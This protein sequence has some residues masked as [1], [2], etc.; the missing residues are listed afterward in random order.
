M[1]EK[2]LSVL[3]DTAVRKEEEAI[4][5][6]TDL[7]AQVEDVSV[8]DTL[9]FIASEERKHR[10]FLL[11]YREGRYGPADLKVSEPV[12]YRIA[13]YQEEPKAGKAMTPAEAFLLASHR[14]LRAHRFY[15]EL[16]ELHTEGELR[17]MILK[18]AGEELRHKEKMEYLYVN[19]AFP[20]TSGG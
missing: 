15:S 13:E 20:Q 2:N 17:Q 5:F 16:S 7:M 1:A 9:S 6:Y 12:Y 4:A 3:I 19:A 10:A 18:M 8:R 11:G 14:E